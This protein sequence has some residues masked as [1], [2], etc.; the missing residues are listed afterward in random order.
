MY[1][2]IEEIKEDGLKREFEKSPEFFPVL[3]EMIK[4]GECKFAA[5]IRTTANAHRIGDMIQLNGEI[6]TLVH[7]SCGR[8]LNDFQTPLNSEF[9]LT[10]VRRLPDA[11]LDEDQ[12]EVEI[13]ADEAGLIYFEGDEI[14]LQEGIQE[15]V[16]LMLPIKALCRKDCK[17]LCINCG[18]DLNRGD[19]GCDRRPPDNKFA[20][21]KD[22]KLDK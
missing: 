8:C 19:C 14:N 17:G 20:A 11:R 16:I 3:S 1:I 18:A 4:L 6:D 15:Q 12:D 22:L 21:L 9:E 2:Q 7:L 13:R 10:Y 5:P